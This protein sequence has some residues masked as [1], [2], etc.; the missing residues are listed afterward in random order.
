[1]T[2]SKMYEGFL[3]TSQ[4][5][6][7]YG[8]VKLASPISNQ[9]KVKMIDRTNEKREF[10]AEDLNSYAF[11][12]EKFN[13][14]NKKYEI[15]QVVYRRKIMPKPP[16]FKGPN[17]VLVKLKVDGPINL[18]HY[19]LENT[20][21]ANI[22]FIYHPVIETPNAGL[23]LLTPQNYINELKE[24]L[25]DNGDLIEKVGSNGFKFKD[26]HETLEMYNEWKRRN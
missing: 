18:Y 11:S 6:T 8:Q 7:I 1:M 13:P 4:K 16:V 2:A 9:L 25:K 21:Q 22:P 20:P 3:V 23:V 17:N 5:D 10:K 26:I 24:I 14:K 12:F 15:E 19:F